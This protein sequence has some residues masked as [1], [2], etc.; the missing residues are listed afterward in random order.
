MSTNLAAAQ[1]HLSALALD[2]LVLGEDVTDEV[3]THLLGCTLCQGRLEQVQAFDAG[4][5]LMPPMRVQVAAR[6]ED[7]A[8]MA[9]ADLSDDVSVAPVAAPVISLDERRRARGRRGVWAGGLL[10]VAAAGL[11]MLRQAPT[12][13]VAL[14]S[15]GGEPADVLRVRGGD[16]VFAGFDIAFVVHDGAQARTV[17]DLDVVHAGERLG[18]RLTMP[19]VGHVAILGIDESGEPYRCHPQGDGDEM[20]EHHPAAAAVAPAA[21]GGAFEVA[22][23]ETVAFDEALGVERLVAIVCED[24]RSMASLQAALRSGASAVG[25]QA[26]LPLLAEGC[27]QREIRLRKQ[28]PPTDAE[29]P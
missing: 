13:V 23:A 11:L 6:G 2:A 8:R 28:A 24:S 17:G 9:T 7:P 20:A 1:G 21:S 27:V 5:Q 25:P 16:R 15:L 3:R 14:N 19:A 4:L 26:P 29:T 22:V 10:A 18:F 12:S